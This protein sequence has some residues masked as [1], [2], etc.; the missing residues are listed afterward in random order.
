MRY[1]PTSAAIVDSLKKQAKKLQRKGGG[2]HAD[3]LDRV[4][5]SAGYQHWHH[6]TLCHKQTEAK[7]GVEA[8]HADCEIILR[9]AR[10]GVDKVIVTNAGELPIPLVMFA[11]Q[12]DAWLLDPEDNLALCLMFHG[13]EQKRVFEDSEREIRIGWDGTY[14]LDGDAF[15]VKTD[16]PLV[17]E[18]V[19][20]GF[21]L[22]E[23]RKC[24][25]KAQS[26]DKRFST[27]IAQDDAVDLTPELVARLIAQGWDAT[28]IKQGQ[29]D[30]AR[31]SPSRNS[32][33]YP[34]VV[35]G[36]GDDDDEG[37]A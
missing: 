36:F 24:I 37:P 33:L 21:P 11:S 6:V 3:L 22:E 35:G 16:H 28:M 4:A 20:L 15:V 30:G 7:T 8:L 34:Q 14:A 27:L 29:K 12:Q 26:F 13:E 31:Y 2:K 19:I 23:L 32:L 18:R 25:D 17:G 1:I 10:E 5:K 9:A